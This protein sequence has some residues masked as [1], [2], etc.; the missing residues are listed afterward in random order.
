MTSNSKQGKGRDGKNKGK[1]EQPKSKNKILV[2]GNDPVTQNQVKKMT[3]GWNGSF[4]GEG[5]KGQPKPTVL[6]VAQPK[7]AVEKKVEHHVVIDGGILDLVQLSA[8]FT[9]KRHYDV[10]GVVVTAKPGKQIGV[11]FSGVRIYFHSAP[12]EHVLHDLSCNSDFIELDH[13]LLGVVPEKFFK[14]DDSLRRMCS[15]LHKAYKKAN[16]ALVLAA[17]GPKP[18]KP[19][20]VPNVVEAPAQRSAE[21]DKAEVVELSSSTEDFKAGKPGVYNLGREGSKTATQV[22]VFDD[23]KAIR[24]QVI[25]AE[26]RRFERTAGNAVGFSF[27]LDQLYGRTLFARHIIDGFTADDDA[28]REVIDFLRSLLR[29][30]VETVVL[31][32]ELPKATIPEKPAKV[33][34]IVTGEPYVVP[35][36]KFTVDLFLKGRSGECEFEGVKLRGSMSYNQARGLE[37][38]EVKVISVPYDHPDCE[39]LRLL[40]ERNFL[41]TFVVMNNDHYPRETLIPALKSKADGLEA[42]WRLLRRGFG[43]PDGSVSNAAEKSSKGLKSA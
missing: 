28:K 31:K 29:I 32:K 27:T 39:A 1:G 10:D 9:G 16:K 7:P 21:T 24:C 42:L 8:G 25:N 19:V 34:S 37:R 13:V 15:F 4:A 2:R 11:Y 38:F 5:P 30:K 17:S 41:A 22:K 36:P 35:A 14:G 23:G 20:E 12:D 26:G 3:T 40:N 33:V 43:L 6:R 18:A